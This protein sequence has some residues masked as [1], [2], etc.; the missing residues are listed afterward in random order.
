MNFISRPTA[1]FATAVLLAFAS[2][3][4]SA[5]AASPKEEAN[6]KVV[7]DF[8]EKGLNQKDADAFAALHEAV[9]QIMR[10][11]PNIEKRVRPFKALMKRSD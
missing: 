6:R 3:A 9:E 8:Y 2:N 7:L 4:G 10:D 5:I 1:I 11:D